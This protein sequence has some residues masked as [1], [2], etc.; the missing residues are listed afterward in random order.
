MSAILVTDRNDGD[1]EYSGLDFEVLLV[2]ECPSKEGK[3]HC[4][5]QNG[6]KCVNGACICK[7]GIPCQCPCDGDKPE[8]SKLRIGLVIGIV[9]PLFVIF[10][11]FFVWY[12]RRKIQKS[13]AQKQVIEEKEA[14]LDVFRNSVVGM[15]TA[16]REYVPRV[17]VDGNKEV[18]G[19]LIGQDLAIAVLPIWC[20]EETPYML[21]KHAPSLLFGEDCWIK[22]DSDSNSKLEAVFRAQGRTGSFSPLPGYVVDFDCWTQ[23]KTSTGFQRAV[24]RVVNGHT[25]AKENDRNEIDLTSTQFGSYLPEE[26]HGEPQ[27]VL[28]KGDVLQISTQRQDGWAFG[29]KVSFNIIYALHY[30]SSLQS[31]TNTH[32]LSRFYSYTTATRPWPESWSKWPPENLV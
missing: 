7:G 4:E 16:V 11:G 29:T 10:F 30:C 19:P 2:R 25:D 9:V 24:Q 8:V 13:R 6:A 23:T 26:L 32:I 14:E 28:V 5:S 17:I 18:E 1:A 31:D 20:W 21:D 27:I 15:R 22:Y 12:R 3:K